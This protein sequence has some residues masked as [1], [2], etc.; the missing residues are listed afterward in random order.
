MG[1]DRY[2]SAPPLG[3]RS[4]RCNGCDCGIRDPRTIAIALAFYALWAVVGGAT[5]RYDGRLQEQLVI[6]AATMTALVVAVIVW[7]ASFT[8]TQRNQA[9]GVSVILGFLGLVFPTFVLVWVGR[10]LRSHLDARRA[11]RAEP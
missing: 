9:A 1:H 3:R 8:D 2:E 5:V 4:A 11:E 7:A 10:A 6:T